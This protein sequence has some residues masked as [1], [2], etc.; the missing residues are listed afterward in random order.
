VV[1]VLLVLARFSGGRP[2]AIVV[3]VGVTVVVTIGVT[4]VVVMRVTVVVVM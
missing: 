1:V 2:V 4:V 3:V